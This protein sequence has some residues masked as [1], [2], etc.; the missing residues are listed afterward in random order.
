VVDLPRLVR[1]FWE[2]FVA[3]A[4]SDATSRLYEVFHFDDNERS[5][6]ELADLV[7]RGDKRATA[8]LVWVFEAKHR[9]IPKPRDLSVVTRWDGRPVCVIET[10]RVEIHPYD[11]VE[12]RS[13][14][15]KG[16]GTA[17]YATGA[18][19][20]AG[21]SRGSV[22]VSAGLRSLGCRSS[23]SALTSCI[24]ASGDRCA[25]A[26]AGHAPPPC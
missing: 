26:S 15:P 14:R 8:G 1:P 12:R 25:H 24:P 21:S 18:R 13:R 22:S 16:K 7:L 23:A 10:T 4:G 17:R 2:A 9:P 6:D 5:A 20:T 11:E 3:T 19:R